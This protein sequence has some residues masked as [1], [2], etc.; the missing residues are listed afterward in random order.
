MIYWF[1]KHPDY[2]R[3]ESIK[4]STDSNYKELYQERDRTF[5]SHGNIL[6]RLNKIHRFP[7][8][9]VYSDATP[10]ELPL[11]FLLKEQLEA[12]F[13]HNLASLDLGQ[14]YNAIKGHIHYHYDL[15]HQNSSGVLCVVEWDNLDEGTQ[16]LG[17]T[18]ILQRVRDWCKGLVTGE[19]PPDSQ[20]VEYI[21]HF[22]D[23][24][25]EIKWV[26]PESFLDER[27]ASGEAFA[28]QYSFFPKTEETKQDQRIYMGT[29]II[30]ENEHGIILPLEF[31]VPG[32]LKEAGINGPYDL[33]TQKDRLNSKLN[34][35]DLL[36]F[37]WFHVN[38]EP[39]PFQN[40][41]DLVKIIGE[42]DTDVGLVKLHRYY[43]DLKTKPA[44]FFIGLRFKNRKGESE[45]QL[46]RVWKNQENSASLL[47]VNSPV[48]LMKYFIASYTRVSA[49]EGEKLTD[50]TYHLRNSGRANREKLKRK[51]VNIVGTG[52]L[53][54]EIADIIAKAGPGAMILVDNQNMKAHNSV[55]HLAGFRQI[56]TPKVFAVA[57]ILRQHNPFVLID[58]IH[59]GISRLEVEAVFLDNSITVSSIADDN[60]EAFLNERM[61]IHGKTMYYTRALRGGKAARIFRV[62]PG[63]DACFHC[64][65]LYRQDKT[66]FIDIPDD[67][68]LP[69]LKNEC[70]NPIR[71]ASAAD[72]KL[73]AAIT[74]RIVID[75]LQDG[76]VEANQWIW[77]TEDIETTVPIKAWQLH[78]QY[79]PPHPRCV[80]CHHDIHLKTF[81]DEEEL[82]RMKALVKLNP[83]I[84]TGGVLAG[85]M[86]A[87]GD[88]DIHYASGPGPNAICSSTR[89]EKDV[90]FCQAF[91]DE[92]LKETGAVY[93]GE[94]H[95]HPSAD[96]RPSGTDLK[97]LNGIAVER[98]YLTDHPVMIILSSEG[99]PS[100]T[101][102]PANKIHY[103][104]ELLTKKNMALS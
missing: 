78:S 79:I 37:Y 20:E 39:E 94:W 89:F 80:Y 66:E 99:K 65:N 41:A 58:C 76:P 36:Q 47:G 93:L 81:I 11:I 30:G 56:G 19:F 42:G 87:N 85:F 40:A 73:I 64:L 3:A 83:A 54:S 90:E 98:D 9:V 44:F 17:I 18:T 29:L 13:V 70:N 72:L 60:T 31:E 34:S 12:E 69:T 71:P 15:R 28:G 62:I 51:I 88:F 55:R 10:F 91:L 53:G 50:N 67:T 1:K 63:K 74:S 4:L 103:Q 6:V 92:K 48:E 97:S 7:I 5:L 45:F 100:C 57:E 95:S 23:V 38:S 52:A 86:T 77:S 33:Y 46:F 21:A 35:R 24:D 82:K 102:H 104:S 68:N 49:I 61:V 16:Y 96:T 27:L 75:H 84:E 25:P 26:Y 101:V 2:L 8:L 32:F 43:E 22:N 59:H 14:I